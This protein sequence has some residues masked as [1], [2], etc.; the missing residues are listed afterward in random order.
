MCIII[1]IFSPGEHIMPPWCSWLSRPLHMRKVSSSNLDEAI[2]L[3]RGGRRF[4]L[5]WGAACPR[6]APHAGDGPPSCLVVTLRRPWSV[7]RARRVYKVG[8]NC[9]MLET[10][11]LCFGPP[12]SGRT[13]RRSGRSPS[14]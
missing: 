1:I 7:A 10:E 2:F 4:V 6:G 12:L 9:L 13:C 5:W 8:E 11:V 14:I 3:L